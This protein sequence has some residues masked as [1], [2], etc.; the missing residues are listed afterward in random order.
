M[1]VT[2]GPAD[3]GTLDHT[4]WWS[5]LSIWGAAMR[6]RGGLGLALAVL[7]AVLA[8]AARS[9]GAQVPRA[10]TGAPDVAG[11][12]WINSAPLTLAALRGRVVLVEFWTY[13]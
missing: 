1:A 10:G 7:V 4:G 3:S 5:M 13:G 12:P 8:V 11:G 2:I 9:A 6:M